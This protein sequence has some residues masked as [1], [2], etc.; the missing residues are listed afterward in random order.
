M[1]SV[2]GLAPLL[3]AQT[4]NS[5]SKVFQIGAFDRSP[6]GFR[7]GE[8][9]AAVTFVVG[10]SDPARDWYGTQPAA[11]AVERKTAEAASAPRTIQ[12]AIEGETA[13]QYRLHLAVVLGDRAVPAIAVTIN[14]R[15][16]VFYL[17]S[18]LSS[19][20]GGMDDQFESAY[21]PADVTIEFPGSY[22]HKGANSI[23]LEVL[24]VD[25]PA[26]LP[27]GLNYDAIE[28]D[29]LQTAPERARASIQPTVF[30]K[31]NGDR[32]TE[33]VDVFVQESDAGE[34]GELDLEVN[35][36]H[37]K[38]PFHAKN[39][40]GEERFEFDVPE[41]AVA[42][43]AH[44]S[45]TADGK[46]SHLDERID[47]QKKWTVLL[48]PHIHL[49]IG[50][51]DYQAKVAAIQDRVVDEA[52][53]FTKQVPDFRYSTDGSWVLDQFMQTRSAADRE[54]L[55]TAMRK[56]EIF[57][58]AE[59]ANLLTGFPTAETL[60][61]SLYYSANFSREHGTPFNYA[62]ITDVPSYSWS[63]AS[64]LAAAGIKYFVA[65]PNGRETHAPVL[66]QGHLNENSP[67]WWEGP[68]GKKVLFWYS[69]HYWEMGIFFGTPPDISVAYQTV[70][71]LLAPYQRPGY[72]SDSMI[73]YGSQQENTDLFP[74]QASFASAWNEKYAY[75]KMEYSGFYDAMKK[76]TAPF[77]DDLPTVRGDGGPYWED[78]IASTAELSALERRTESRG[79][80]VEQL[81]TVS[82]LVNPHLAAD[83]ER[84]DRM[85]RD[86]VLMDEHTWTSHDSVK[87]PISDETAV[88]SA[89][90]KNY[91]TDASTI[92]DFV[93]QNSMANL[94]DSIS[95]SRKSV[96]VFNTLN[97]KRSGVVTFD[98]HHGEVLVDSTTGKV[99]PVEILTKGNALS[100]VRFVASE[101]PGNGYKVFEIRKGT[102][103][104]E[105]KVTQ[106]NI[107]ENSFYRVT[108][109]PSTGTV[110]SIFD[111]ELK[112]EL[113]NQNS[114][115]RFGQYLYVTGGDKQPNSL[116]T[117]RMVPI[118]P[119]LQVTGSHGGRLISSV[120]TA[121]GWVARMESTDENTPSVRVEIRLPEHEKKVEF[122]EDISKQKVLAKEA[123]YF[124][125]PFAMD[126]PE[127]N[128]EIQNGVVN[129]AKD[130]YPGA[131]HE[132][133]SVQ[134]WVSVQQDG[135]SGTIMPLDAGLVTLGD[136]Y[137]GRWPSH[138]EDRN[139]TVF[140]YAMNNTWNTN[141]DAGQGGETELR[142]VVTSAPSTDPVALS[143]MGW[144]AAT[145]LES[146]EITHQ[147]KAVDS[148]RLLNGKQGRFLE[149]DDPNVVVE[150]W[151]PAE[152]GKGT[153]LR[154]LDLGGAERTV[155]VRTPL[156]KLSSVIET[157]AVE[158]DEHQLVSDGSH[159]FSVTVHPHEIVTVRI[160]GADTASEL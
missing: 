29:S 80:S 43:E 131:G 158:R 4:A 38:H 66:I 34:H 26:E 105:S 46:T 111:K 72:R 35:G 56:Q 103:A 95:A 93:A 60:I 1:A 113:V 120:H 49:D 146:D 78:G 2:L 145:P 150:A 142:Y 139:G 101:V 20:L 28:L 11:S 10:K 130:M 51:S 19:V 8:P 156:L 17:S 87:E 124:A 31:R 144:E 116:Q 108:L 9:K 90:K 132:W 136:I 98:L 33:L 44:L 58:P 76:I 6:L 112:K 14:G 85:W 160:I 106:S 67:F 97:W 100:R 102:A 86:M 16:G 147:D 27:A 23:A 159:A 32:L 65:G 48:V 138:F 42:T 24:R 143:R 22:L 115:Y 84:L 61:R 79:P 125:F 54:R 128:F 114:P 77:G 50:Y 53:D 149:I 40:F 30:Y 129:P 3:K 135:V 41:F 140:S 151:K 57:V 69:R 157:D 68:D 127:F 18:K 96:I 45:W 141:Y 7:G 75:P 21:V 133:F 82:S 63:Y 99:M 92:A 91:V 36:T 110:Q 5:F 104:Q 15:R 89:V 107:L 137:R 59:Y 71:L 70:P 83:K 126:H 155:S 74:Q 152:D 88:Q 153:M 62:D 47:P 13:P 154:L 121:D 55:L 122:V 117:F 81:A 109:D 134:H 148:Q 119:E 37:Y 39:G 25:E 118:P 52:M 123:V 12:F 94:A 64:I 73:V